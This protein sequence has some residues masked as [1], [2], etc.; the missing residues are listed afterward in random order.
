MC[1]YDEGSALFIPMSCFGA[2]AQAAG[3]NVRIRFSKATKD[4][5]APQMQ[6]EHIRGLHSNI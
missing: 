6:D 5:V 4:D 2:A 1:A 3:G